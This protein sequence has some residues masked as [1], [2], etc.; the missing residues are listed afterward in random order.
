[1]IDS[2]ELQGGKLL[3][4][5]GKTSVAV[6]CVFA[7][8]LGHLYSAIAVDDPRL[9]AY[10][11]V[12]STTPDYPF[13]SR[14]SSKDGT[15]TQ[16]KP[17]N[18]QVSSVVINC[19]E[20]VLE[21]N[22]NRAVQVEGDQIVR[23]TEA[24]LEEL[25][26]TG[27]LKGGKQPFLIN[28]RFSVLGSFVIALKLAHLYSAIAVYDPKIGDSEL[29]KY[30][31]VISHNGYQVGETIDVKPSPSYGIKVVLCGEANTGKTCLKEGLKNSLLKVPDAPESYVFSGCPDG[32]GAWHSETARNNTELARQLKD[33]Y[34]AQ[35]TSQFAQAKAK[36]I[37]AIKTP[38]LV[39]DVG[40]KITPENKTIMSEATHAVILAK[41]EEGVQSWQR[42][43]NQLNLPVVAIINSDYEAREDYFET[44]SPLLKGKVHY[45]DRGEDTSTRPMI[46]KLAQ[47]LVNLFQAGH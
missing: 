37:K 45:L 24:R 44:D 13:S 47:Y 3:T 26:N 39:F 18:H 27:Q 42:F 4:I 23:D 19:N 14:I 22:L 29:D 6:A 33:E 20:G 15:V 12:S 46:K 2:G 28:G 36:E 9:E 8:K 41:S 11:V 30:I 25:I 34:K 31:V 5:S 7:H 16:T 38:I 43:C 21:T 1:M 10:V 35:F 40:G 17:D 32:E